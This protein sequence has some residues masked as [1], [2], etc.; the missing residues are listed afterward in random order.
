MYKNVSELEIAKI[1]TSANSFA[2]KG[3]RHMTCREMSLAL[4]LTGIAMKHHGRSIFFGKQCRVVALHW[5]QNKTI[6]NILDLV[7]GHKHCSGYDKSGNEKLN[8]VHT[9][10]RSL[11][12]PHTY[13]KSGIALMSLTM[14]F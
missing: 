10:Q 14:A 4:T 5:L 6:E 3:D 7:L 9:K 12:R 1:N 11:E 2:D 13:R 8:K